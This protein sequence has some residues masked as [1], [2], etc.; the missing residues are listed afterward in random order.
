MSLD[1]R[2]KKVKILEKDLELTSFFKKD[3]FALHRE[4]ILNAGKLN[5]EIHGTFKVDQGTKSNLTVKCHILNDL[6]LVEFAEYFHMAHPGLLVDESKS[7]LTNPQTFLYSSEIALPEGNFKL[8]MNDE[9]VLYFMLDNRFSK[10]T[11]KKIRLTVWEEWD[12]SILPLDVV[13]TTPPQDTSIDESI[14]KMITSAKKHLKI[15]SPYVDMYLIKELLEQKEKGIKIF[16]VT[17]DVDEVKKQRGNVQALQFIQ[18]AFGENHKVNPFIHSRIII[19]DDLEA[20]VSS[21]DL[22][23]DS[24]R[25]HYNAGL[26]L[27][28]P[29]LLQKLLSYFKQIFKD[30]KNMSQIK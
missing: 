1:T 12:E 23:R 27:S 29:I 30:S 15:L 25:S 28:D 2:H 3:P 24:L 16:I 21:A 26:I 19:K 14:Q 8:K 6:Q 20:M 11:P 22:T 5:H 4:E 9:N 13:T 7:T 10:L 18:D 17:R